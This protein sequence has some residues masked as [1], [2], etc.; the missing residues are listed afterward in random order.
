MNIQLILQ[1]A[2][3]QEVSQTLAGMMAMAGVQAS[4]EEVAEAPGG[5]DPGMAGAAFAISIPPEVLAVVE[6]AERMEKQQ[7]ANMLLE[8]LRTFCQGRDVNVIF[9]T[10][11]EDKALAEMDAD[12]LL[13]LADK[14]AGKA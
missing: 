1:G 8:S 6:L 9:R 2:D 11:S 10:E 14:L 13:E 3:A 5:T 12:T 4:V 7:K